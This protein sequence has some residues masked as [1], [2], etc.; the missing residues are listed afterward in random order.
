MRKVQLTKDPSVKR[1]EDPKS[2]SEDPKDESESEDPKPV[3][4]PKRVLDFFADETQKF[5][6]TED[7]SPFSLTKLIQ[8]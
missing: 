3:P 2:E 7:F 4:M 1:V 5:K 8:R 6:A